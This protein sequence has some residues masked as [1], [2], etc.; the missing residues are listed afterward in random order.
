MKTIV[1][2]ATEQLVQI[3]SPAGPAVGGSVERCLEQLVP[4]APPEY[5]HHT[6][7]VLEGLLGPLGHIEVHEGLVDG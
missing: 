5:L 2:K 3:E 4:Q 7:E 1:I 6:S